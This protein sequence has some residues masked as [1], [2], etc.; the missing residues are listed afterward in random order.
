MPSGQHY[1]TEWWPV[2]YKP[3]PGPEMESVCLTISGATL[4]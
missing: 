4:L 3:Q 2:L 1:Q